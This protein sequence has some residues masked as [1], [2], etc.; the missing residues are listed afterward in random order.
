MRHPGRRVW[1]V[2]GLLL[3]AAPALALAQVTP[4]ADQPRGMILDRVVASVNDEAITLSEIQ[5]EGQ[6]VIRKIVQDFVGE[7]RSRRVDQAEQRLLKDLIDRR[8]LYQVAKKE[9]MLPSTAEVQ[10]ARWEESKE[11]IEELEAMFSSTRLFRS[12]T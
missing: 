9:G 6:P 4:K 12:P 5:E 8:L 11:R 7:E 10:G 1:P 3:T 2:L